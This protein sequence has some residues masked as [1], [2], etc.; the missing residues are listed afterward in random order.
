MLSQQAI[1]VLTVKQYHFW[2]SIKSPRYSPLVQPINGVQYLLSFSQHWI[3]I[4][5]TVSTFY[6]D[7]LRTKKIHKVHI[8][9]DWLCSFLFE[10]LA[11]KQFNKTSHGGSKAIV[12]WSLAHQ[13]R[14]LNN[15]YLNLFLFN[16]P[17]LKY[18][19]NSHAPHRWLCISKSII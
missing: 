14:L 6:L 17:N 9:I 7:I 8:C 13:S 16:Q 10:L 15:K 19:V 4:L 5:I 2:R 18:S 11:T 3:S 1:S 12:I